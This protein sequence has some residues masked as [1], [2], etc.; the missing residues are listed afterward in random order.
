M[1]EG[2]LHQRDRA[3]RGLLHRNGSLMRKPEDEI[4]DVNSGEMSGV[5]V[6][7]T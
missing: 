1:V 4:A 3:L 5:R 2:T 7:L 6:A